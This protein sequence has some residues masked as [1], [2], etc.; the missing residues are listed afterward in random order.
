[1][2]SLPDSFFYQMNIDFCFPAGSYPMEQAHILG[3]EASYNLIV[4]HFLM[5][6]QRINGKNFPKN[7]IQP[8]HFLLVNFKDMFITKPLNTAGEADARSNSSFLL[9]SLG[10]LFSPSPPQIPDS[11]I[12]FI[13]KSSCSEHAPIHQ[14]VLAAVFHSVLH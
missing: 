14:K 10:K 6:I 4:C 8:S 11:S 7:G 3:L 1:M 5:F 12:Y 9:T 13:S 2:F